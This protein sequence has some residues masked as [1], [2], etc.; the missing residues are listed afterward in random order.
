MLFNWSIS[1]QSGINRFALP[2]YTNTNGE[3]MYERRHVEPKKK[4]LDVWSIRKENEKKKHSW[5]L[6]GTNVHI[7]KGKD[8]P[9]IFSSVAMTS[10]VFDDASC[11]KVI[12]NVTFIRGSCIHRIKLWADFDSVMLIITIEKWIYSYRSCPAQGALYSC[13]VCAISD[14]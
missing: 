11:L 2:F 12:T 6:S 5:W 14:K 7:A 9:G 13:M 8:E 3:R 1:W 4:S 10:N